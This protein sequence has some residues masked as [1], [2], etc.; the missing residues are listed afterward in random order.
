MVAG[1]SITSPG[2]ADTNVIEYVEIASTGDGADFGDLTATLGK[3]GAVN[4][5]TRSVFGGGV[6]QPAKTNIMDYVTTASTGNATDFG[7]LTVARDFPAGSSNNTRGVF[8][9]GRSPGS[10]ETIDYITIAS[11]GNATDFGD[12]SS[13]GAVAM[14]G[15]ASN[16]HGGLS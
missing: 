5:S 4:S 3:R 10:D 9:G 6:N 11:T 13:V 7:D 16:G 1:G 15:G 2:Q 14:A 8:A 12:T